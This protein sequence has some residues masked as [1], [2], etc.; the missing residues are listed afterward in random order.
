MKVYVIKYQ[1]DWMKD[2]DSSWFKEYYIHA[3]SK[4]EAGE[5]FGVKL[6]HNAIYEIKESSLKEEIVNILNEEIKCNTFMDS[7]DGIEL[8]LAS[9]IIKK[10]REIK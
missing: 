9:L 5:K 7:V 1:L 10:V 2:T 8:E 4:E 3:N 6:L